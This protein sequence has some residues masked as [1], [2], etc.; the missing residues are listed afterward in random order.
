MA[1][2]A[3]IQFKAFDSAGKA[4]AAG[5]RQLLFLNECNHIPF[6][7]ADTLITRTDDVV[8][9]DFNPDNEFWAHTEIIPLEDAEFLL[10]K[11]SDNE[12]LPDSI[13]NDLRQK[14]EKAKTSKYW[15]NWCK[16]YIDGEIGNLQGAVFTH[17]KEIDEDIG[18]GGL[19]EGRKDQTRPTKSPE[20]A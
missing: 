20:A 3:R 1:N 18:I 4:K 10:L 16:V 6:P 19:L 13:M 12:A 5:K 11:Y 14:Q 17:W 9:M 8:W 7:I 2:G 15:A